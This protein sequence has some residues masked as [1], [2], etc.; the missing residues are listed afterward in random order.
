[1]INSL[2]VRSLSIGESCSWT[3][4]GRREK[5]TRQS[6]VTFTVEEFLPTPATIADLTIRPNPAVEADPT[7]ES[8]VKI[9]FRDV[10]VHAKVSGKDTPQL[11]DAIVYGGGVA[12]FFAAPAFTAAYLHQSLST[13]Q[14][15]AVIA[16][17]ELGAAI[18]LLIYRLR[19]K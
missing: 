12:G 2:R 1:M 8:E 4:F 19:G 9:S 5:P 6:E 16:A 14:L 15:I 7:H 17:E 3:R 18:G 13:T 11:L 10:G